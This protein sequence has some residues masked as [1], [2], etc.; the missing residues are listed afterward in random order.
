MTGSDIIK[1]IIFVKRINQKKLADLLGLK[2]QQ[3]ISSMLNRS[4]SMKL[5][6]FIRMAEAMGC[7]VIV[8]DKESERSWQVSTEIAVEPEPKPTV[9]TKRSTKPVSKE[10]KEFD[11]DAFIKGMEKK[12][13]L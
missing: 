7:E 3:N 1:E 5:S 13:E 11:I 9:K 2:R 8:K 4:E 12:Y 6:N 10:E